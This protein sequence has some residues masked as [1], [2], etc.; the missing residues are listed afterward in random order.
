MNLRIT[1][2]GGASGGHLYPGLAIVEE[3]NRREPC[4]VQFIGTRQGLESRVIPELG[5]Q[6]NII[7]M[8]GIHRG[9]ILVNLLF[10]VKMLVS[11]IQSL[12]FVLRFMPDVVI[13]TGGYV[14]WPVMMAAW[15][16]RK[17]AFIQEQ[18]QK[19][20]LVTRV[21]APLMQCVFLSYEDTRSF[22]RC[23]HKL[24]VCGNP[25]RNTLTA[26]D[27]N[28]GYREFGLRPDKTTLFIF[29]GSQGAL[30]I[31]RAVSARIDDLMKH[32][33]QI[34]WGTGPRWYEEIARKI[35]PYTN[36]IVVMPYIHNMAAAYA[37]S[38]LIICRSGA[39]TVAEIN[40]L[41]KAALYIP[42]PGAAG[43]HQLIN[44][45]ALVHSHAAAMVLESEI[46]SGRLDDC[47][48]D[49]IGNPAK[50]KEM[51]RNALK[52]G[53]PDAAACIADYILNFSFIKQGE[54]HED[55]G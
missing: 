37:V 30:G 28:A 50:R 52:F 29:G 14:S 22:F 35:K 47:M 8:A 11:L 13:G 23:Q 41:G 43:N 39:T 5:Y 55:T 10:P 25:T 3:L 24:F 19:P 54:C 53:F 45:K 15:M 9:R 1:L 33:I 21:L 17:P 51:G 18:N 7:W 2:T 40:R 27:R 36:R 42:F 4:E 31:N 6:F 44:A 16:I 46:E 32:D 48:L 49:L 20:G 38:D 26:G 34:L 12:F